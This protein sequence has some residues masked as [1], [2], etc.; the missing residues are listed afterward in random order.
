[1]KLGVPGKG[2]LTSDGYD[3]EAGVWR[4]GLLG[5]FLSS[6]CLVSMTE[7]AEILRVAILQSQGKRW[8]KQVTL[9]KEQGT[10]V[11]M[12]PSWTGGRS[13]YESTREPERKRVYKPTLYAYPKSNKTGQNKS[14]TQDKDKGRRVSRTTKFI[15]G[16]DAAAPSSPCCVNVALRS[17]IEGSRNARARDFCFALRA[18]IGSTRVAK[19]PNQSYVVTTVSGCMMACQKA[20]HS[21]PKHGAWIQVLVNGFRS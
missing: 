9:T 11:Y 18:L 19:R 17:P 4:V 6:L 12:N 13:D 16:M 10:V 14:S 1:M 15:P 5:R 21:R 20:F 2:L 8:T 7:G 3:E